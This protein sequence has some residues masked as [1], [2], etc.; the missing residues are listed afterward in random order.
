[1][2]GNNIK[3]LRLEKHYSQEQLARK[4][5]LSQGAIS[6][7]EKG[8][9]SPD[10]PVLIQLAKIFEVSLDSLTDET[11]PDD[12]EGFIPMRRNAVPVIGEIACGTPIYAEE[13]IDGYVDLPDRVH[14][15]FALR[16]KGDSMEP[17]FKDGDY[18]LIRKQP[19]VENGQ[20]AAI[21][22]GNEATLKHVY[23]F[24]D[25]ITLTAENP[26]YPPITV[27]FGQDDIIIHGL[28][29]GYTRVFY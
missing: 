25:H 8:K 26:I 11:L 5:N 29:V 3:R 20:I 6:Q 22:I 24:D 16:C 9:T 2:I 1:V 19:V 14:A 17:T 4:L 21:T 18:V 7:W 23:T 27:P 13:N 10:T 15:D 12:I 28:A